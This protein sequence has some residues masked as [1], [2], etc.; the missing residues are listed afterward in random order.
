MKDI[1]GEI[2]S[3]IDLNEPAPAPEA[4]EVET[5]QVETQEAEQPVEQ[6]AAPEQDTDAKKSFRELREQKEQLKRER[7][8]ALRMLQFVEKN[9]SQKSQPKVEAEDEDFNIDSLQ[10]DEYTDN[11]K[12]KKI[13]K[14]QKKSYA[15]LEEKL[16]QTAQRNYQQTVEARIRAEFPDYK[17]VVSDENIAQ[18]RDSKPSIF[19]SL[20]YNPDMYEQAAGA[21]EA[22]KEFGI[23][24]PNTYS[25]EDAQLARNLAKPKP[26][27]SVGVQKKSSP[28]DSLSAYE[29]GLSKEDA[30][31]LYADTKKKAG[32]GNY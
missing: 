25:R 12:L 27:S 26:V 11:K 17:D 6:Q 8:E 32:W 15:Q 28:L 31:R 16:Q 2:L 4:P 5:E 22:I 9:L 18:L 23:Y 30:D 13:L 29:H 24:K 14:S 19:R 21:Y 10:D 1:T 20:S 7:D 3:R